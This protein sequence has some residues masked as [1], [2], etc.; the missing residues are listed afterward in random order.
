[1][2]HKTMMKRRDA[3]IAVF[4]LLLAVIFLRGIVFSQD[5]VGL[6]HDWLFPM[7]KDSL[8]MYYEKSLFGWSDENLGYSIVYPAENI[9]RISTLPFIYIGLSGLDV[10]KI[11]LI[12]SLAVAGFSMYSLL[13][14]TLQH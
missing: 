7:T 1:M 9:L 13:R 11:I 6:N 5:Y 4:F 8:K 14:H 10:L 3:F 12:L 2:E